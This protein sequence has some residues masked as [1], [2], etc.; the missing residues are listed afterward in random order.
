MSQDAVPP[1]SRRSA[2]RFGTRERHRELGAAFA[3]QGEDYD[4]LRPGYPQA[5][6]GAMLADVPGPDAVDLGAGTGKLSRALAQRG[7]TVTAVDPSRRM[8]ETLARAHAQEAAGG[9]AEPG[10]P[11]ATGEPGGSAVAGTLSTRVGTAEETGL[12]AGSADLVTAAQAWHWFDTE[13]ACAEISRI[14]RPG[15]RLALVWNSLDVAVPWVHRYSRIMHAG[16]VLKDDFE[17]PVAPQVTLA[18]RSVH[19]WEDARP[20]QELIDLARTRSYVIAAS[21]EQRERVLG[22]LDW[23][24]HEHLGHAPGTVVGLP[25]RTDVFVFTQR[26]G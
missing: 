15:G 9:A 3:E 22:N 23:Y 24:L 10:E 20:T 1:V 16:D 14:L 19:H 25:Y 11:D 6:V 2:P 8:L 17:P 21:P 12:P 7:M 4:R 26:P 18:R 5:A 13:R